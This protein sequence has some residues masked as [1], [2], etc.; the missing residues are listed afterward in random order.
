MPVVVFLAV[1]CFWFAGPLTVW[2]STQSNPTLEIVTEPSGGFHAMAR[3]YIAAP[4]SVVR[5]V[6]TEYE[7][8][9]ALFNG[10]FRIVRLQR[11]ADRVVTDLMIKRSPLPGE[12]RLL[13]ETRETPDGTLITS[14]LAG[15][16]KRYVR[17]WTLHTDPEGR[18]AVPGGRVGTRAVM[19]LSLE[20]R[21]IVPDW[22]VVYNMRRELLDH[23]RI[24]QEMAV[25]KAG[26]QPRRGQ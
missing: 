8:W 23:F 15:D 21:T 22:I 12:L 18:T 1:L 4:P 24:L 6:L 26:L 9:P 13:C 19:D 2:P 14:L 11:E 25:A 17:R 5:A 16:F 20:L 7:A 10:R 3:F